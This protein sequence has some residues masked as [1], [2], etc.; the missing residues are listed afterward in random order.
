MGEARASISVVLVLEPET[1]VLVAGVW[2]AARRRGRSVRIVLRSMLGAGYW[3]CTCFD[4]LSLVR[5]IEELRRDVLR[6]C[7][8]VGAAEISS[9]GEGALSLTLT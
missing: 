2:R 5:I 6:C 1:E 3:C 9:R 8:G 4:D 7:D